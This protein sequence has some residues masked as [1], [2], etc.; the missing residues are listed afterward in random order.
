ML[1]DFVGTRLKPLSV[2]L[3][4]AWQLWQYKS[5]NM[6]RGVIHWDASRTRCTLPEIRDQI[7]TVVRDQF[8]PSWWRGFGF[9][10]I[11]SLNDF[12]E[13]L[14]DAADLVDVRNNGKG[15]WQWIVLHFPASQAAAGICTWTEGYLAPVYRDLLSS[16]QATGVA[17]ESYR[18]DMDA[19]TKTLR[20]IHKKLRVAKRVMGGIEGL[21]E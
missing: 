5:L 20:D 7:R 10:V 18:K 14:K 9:G 19:F 16:L 17:C 21:L 4:P 6:H 3:P 13:S 12:D 15:C 11:V 8:R 2:D 1:P